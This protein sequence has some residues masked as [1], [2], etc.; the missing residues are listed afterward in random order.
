MENAH[1]KNLRGLT[2]AGL[3]LLAMA[4]VSSVGC[5]SSDDKTGTGGTGG[6]AGGSGGGATITSGALVTDFSGETAFTTGMPYHG[7]GAGW[8]DS[9]VTNSGNLHVVLNT[10]PSTAMYAYAYVGI[11]L[12]MGPVDASAVT[13]VTFTVSGTL[14]GA[15]C[16]IQYSTVDQDHAE[17]VNNGHC[18]TADG[19]YPSSKVFPLATTPTPVTV[20]W[21]DQTGG[22]GFAAAASTV[23]AAQILN[24]QWQVQT[25]AG[26]IGDSCTADVTIDDVKWQ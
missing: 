19:C 21:G 11:P 9:T 24:L 6:G 10:G 25:S 8:A 15:G 16:Q 1:M 12:S 2:L 17:T 3:G 5:S 7:S 23:N 14:T 4:M 20:L 13:G 26:A 18:A 22:M